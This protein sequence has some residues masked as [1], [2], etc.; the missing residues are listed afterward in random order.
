MGLLDAR[1]PLC[2]PMGLRSDF[3]Q[4]VASG[5]FDGQPPLFDDIMERLQRLEKTIND[6]AG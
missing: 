5:M 3:E 4:M 2:A 1:K 6:R